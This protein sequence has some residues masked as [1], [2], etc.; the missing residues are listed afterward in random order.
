MYI[1]VYFF[2]NTS[3][4]VLLKVP[5]L[6]NFALWWFGHQTFALK[7]A[8]MYFPIFTMY[9]YRDKKSKMKKTNHK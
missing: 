6:F 3:F 1:Y 5:M 7:N 8:L 9:L 4:G 2:K